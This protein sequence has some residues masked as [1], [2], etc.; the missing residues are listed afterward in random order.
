MDDIKVVTICGSMKFFEK[1]IEVAADLEIKEG[2]A[3]IQCVYFNKEDNFSKSE[4]DN[5]G[6]IHLKKIAIS[7]AIYVVNVNGYIGS[8]TKKEIEFAK[9]MGKEILY[10]EQVD[11]GR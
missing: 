3:V 8:S 10:L 1:M 9:E 11:E 5:M 2:Y 7:D 6:R 4:I